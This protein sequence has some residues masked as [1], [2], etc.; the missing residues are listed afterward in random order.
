MEQTIREYV[1]ECFNNK[2]L[3]DT[4]NMDE[5]QQD[6]ASALAILNMLGTL[7]SQDLNE[8]YELLRG[9]G[10]NRIK[11]IQ[12]QLKLELEN[13]TIPKM[14]NDRSIAEQLYDVIYKYIIFME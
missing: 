12:T 6:E 9:Y 5:A 2:T 14:V 10:Y 4:D 13:P 8:V 7:A 3:V 1:L 11:Q